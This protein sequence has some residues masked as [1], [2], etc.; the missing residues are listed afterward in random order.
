MT[1]KMA[2]AL[3]RDRIRVNWVTVGWVLTEKEIEV[4]AEEGKDMAA[5]DEIGKGRPMGEFNTVEEIAEGC[6]YLASDAAARVTGSDLNISG[7]RA[8]L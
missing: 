3:A 6:V 8:H 1:K 4:Q 5:L 7:G 2:S